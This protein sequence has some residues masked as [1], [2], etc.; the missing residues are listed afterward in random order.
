MTSDKKVC[1]PTKTNVNGQDIEV[2]QYKYLGSIIDDKLSFNGNTV[3]LCKEGQQHLYCLRKLARFNI[4]K[5]LMTI[6]Y[7]S[8]T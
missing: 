5:S 4:D 6:F 1:N 3:M 2:N 8:F 7:R